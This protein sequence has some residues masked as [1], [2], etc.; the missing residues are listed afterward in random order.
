MGS[1]KDNFKKGAVEMLL[2]TMLC[3]EDMYGYQMAQ[4]VKKRSKGEITIP[5]GSMYPTLYR[6]MSKGYI[7]DH[8]STSGRRQLRVVYYHIEPAGR[9]HLEQ[10]RKDY[11][12]VNRGIQMVMDKSAEVIRGLLEDQ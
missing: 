3:E 6:L 10:I 11:F 7:T 12:D 5:E 2:L 1:A 9:E 8:Q 4:L